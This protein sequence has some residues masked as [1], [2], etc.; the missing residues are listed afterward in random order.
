MDLKRRDNRFG[1]PSLRGFTPD[2]VE[3]ESNQQAPPLV[4]PGNDSNKLKKRAWVPQAE[5]TP[6]NIRRQSE[7]KDRD[8]VRQSPERIIPPAVQSKVAAV[9]MVMIQHSSPWESLKK[10]FSLSL[11]DSV[12]IASRKDGL[13]VAVR[14][15]S[16]P[17]ADREVCTL[18]RIRQENLPNFLAFLECFSFKGSLYAVFEHELTRNEKLLTLSHYALIKRYPTEPQLAFIIGQVS[19]L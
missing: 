16:G 14:E 15:F 12:T 8:E 7:G 13:F 5:E 6:P 1:M 3:N 9:G 4:A 10:R 2:S 18:Q 11:E 19:L 17:D